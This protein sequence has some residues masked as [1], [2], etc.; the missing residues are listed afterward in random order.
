MK[1]SRRILFISAGTIVA[2]GIGI[3]LLRSCNPY[4]GLRIYHNERRCYALSIPGHAR[5]DESNAAHMMFMAP[6][7]TGAVQFIDAGVSP[8]A[9]VKVYR[10]EMEKASP[11]IQ[12]S[13]PMISADE[14]TAR[15][16]SHSTVEGRRVQTISVFFPGQKGD[17]VHMYVLL[18][19]PASQAA[20]SFAN[21]WADGFVWDSSCSY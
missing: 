3:G 8:A 4:A 17:V 14:K 16:T 6:D 9:F 5:P 10:A 12:F 2:L 7:W 18:P 1:K 20:E 15:I 19:E 11:G 21:R 13:E